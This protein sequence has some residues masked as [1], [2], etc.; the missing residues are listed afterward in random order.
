MNFGPLY[1]YSQQQE[2]AVVKLEWMLEVIQE[3]QLERLDGPE[4]LMVEEASH[5]EQEIMAAVHMGQEEEW[6]QMEAADTKAEVEVEPAKWQEAL[7][8]QDY[9]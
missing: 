2:T 9:N 4:W 3:E 8:V 1:G 6:K 5:S 7:V